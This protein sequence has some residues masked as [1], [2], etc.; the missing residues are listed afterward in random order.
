[1]KTPVK[2]SVKN[3]DHLPANAH[4]DI[5]ALADIFGCSRC[6]IFRKFKKGILPK[7]VTVLGHRG[8]LVGTVRRILAGDVIT[9][10]AK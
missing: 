3:F 7:P 4:I 9:K 5:S 8:L 10:E 2:P 6:T 1:M